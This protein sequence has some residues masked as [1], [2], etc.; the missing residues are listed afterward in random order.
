MLGLPSVIGTGIDSYYATFHQGWLEFKGTPPIHTYDLSQRTLAGYWQQTIGLL[1]TTD[2]SYGAR[3]Q[4]TT[5]SARDLLNNP[6]N[7]ALFF[8]CS[9]QNLPVDISDTQYALRLGR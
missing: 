1:S 9:A 2:F 8:T 5:L 6:A 3:V 7:C 4:N